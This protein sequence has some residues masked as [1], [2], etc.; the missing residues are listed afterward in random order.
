MRNK[1]GVTLV[2][3]LGAI[4]V[5]G[6][7]MSISVMVIDYFMDANN[8]SNISSQANVEGLLAIRIMKNSMSDLGPTEYDICTGDNCLIIQSEYSYEFNEGTNTIDLVVYDDPLEYKIEIV[9]NVLYINDVEYIFEG[10]ELTDNSSLA[11]E[12]DN[13]V[14]FITLTLYLSAGDQYTY[15]YIMSYSYDLTDIPAG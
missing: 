8:R 3:L 5:F 9:N 7:L 4:V 2:E 13:S 6:I 10:F 12:E 1:H 15:E 11:Y 14:L